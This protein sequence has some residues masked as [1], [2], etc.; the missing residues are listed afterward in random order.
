MK[1]VVANKNQFTVINFISKIKFLCKTQTIYFL[2]ESSC[3]CINRML[4][5]LTLVTIFLLKFVQAVIYRHEVIWCKY[6]QGNHTIRQNYIQSFNGFLQNRE[7]TMLN[8]RV[9]SV[10]TMLFFCDMTWRF[11]FQD[12]FSLYNSN[13][14]H[15][16]LT[17]FKY[18]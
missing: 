12:I 6:C 3:I 10:C 5:I 14:V 17:N 1:K 13:S 2:Q 8:K 16:N 9:S 7:I 11:F 18:T 15:W 4:L